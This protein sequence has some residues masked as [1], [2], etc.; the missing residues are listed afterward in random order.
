MTEAGALVSHDPRPLVLLHGWA[1]NLRVFDGLVTRLDAPTATP[2]FAI[3]RLDLPGH[4]LAIEPASWRARP[5]DQGWQIDELADHLLAQM[6]PRAA[7]L[8]WSLGAKV[9]L[10]IA[11]RAPQRVSALVLVSATPRF[12]QS[13][14]WPHGSPAERLDALAAALRRDYRRTVSE[15]L[16]LQV[17]GSQSADTTLATLQRS[18]LERG[19]CPPEV[20]LRALRLL[21]RVDQRPRLALITA[22]TLVIAGEYDRVVHP[23]ASRALAGLIGGARFLALPRCGHAPFLSHEAE[24]TAAVQTFLAKVPT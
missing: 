19:E 12:A 2:R 13:P 14:D 9:A 1:L 4:G 5:D 16:S 10:E 15:F 3:T 6:P 18:L 11:A 7:L 8:G 17:R 24:F 21:H 20:L 23:E 22:P